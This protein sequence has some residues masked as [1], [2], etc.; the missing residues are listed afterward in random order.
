MTPPLTERG[1]DGRCPGPPMGF[2]HP[3]HGRH[4]DV[5]QIDWPD[6]YSAGLDGLKG[7]QRA[8]EGGNRASFGL[9]VL[10]DHAVVAR[11]SRL[12]A[13]GIGAQDDH[14]RLYFEGFQGF[15]DPNDE[16]QAEEVQK[17]LGRPH[18]GRPAGRQDDAR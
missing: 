14:S 12:D 11:E 6:E 13:G 18:P 17:G 8:A 10:H 15:Q 9:R 3:L 2:E 4:P 7:A 1:D 5:G 16:G